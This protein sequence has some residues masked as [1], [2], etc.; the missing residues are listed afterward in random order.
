LAEECTPVDRVAN[1]TQAI[2]DLGATVCVRARP[3]CLA[4]PQQARCVARLEGLQHEL[5]TPRP[6]KDRPARAAY[7]LIVQNTA[8][9]VLLERRP[10]TG[11]WGG[12]WTLPQFET[13]DAA[14]AW[15]AQRFVAP[16]SVQALTA[17]EHAFTHFDLTLHPLLV[18]V[19][20]TDAIADEGRYVWYESSAP[21]RIGLAKP[22]VDLLRTV[23]ESSLR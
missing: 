17:Y 10:P 20:R 18:S 12:L 19:E 15:A 8:G 14:L 7:A 22:A 21:L 23:Q 16:A 2:M 6:K 5:P 11:L 4:C 13:C 3:L 9:A 1:Y